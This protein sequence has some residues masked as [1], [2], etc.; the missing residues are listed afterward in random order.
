[1]TT[2][3]YDRNTHIKQL[4]ANHRMIIDRICQRWFVKVAGAY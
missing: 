4:D 3:N 2:W 1:M